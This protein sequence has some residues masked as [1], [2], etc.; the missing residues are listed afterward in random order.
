MKEPK[1][2]RPP[3][4][5]NWVDRV[6]QLLSVPKAE[7]D[8]REAAWKK[9]KRKRAQERARAVIVLLGLACSMLYG[10]ADFRRRQAERASAENA[11]ESQAASIIVTPGDLSRP[12]TILGSVDYPGKGVTQISLTGSPQTCGPDNARRA[13]VEAYGG[14]VGAII[15]F[16]Q[17]RDGSTAHCGGTAVA[18]SDGR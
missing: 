8:R 3:P 13:A 12:Y 15:G 11:R 1:T 14:R 18:F 2:E 6:R 10:C 5:G 16:T 7:I 17:W 9:Q 4:E